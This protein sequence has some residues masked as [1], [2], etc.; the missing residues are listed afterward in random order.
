MAD[1]APRVDDAPVAAPTDLVLLPDNPAPDGIEIVWFENRNRRRV[2][3]AFAPD[4]KG[5][6]KTR[7]TVIVA[8]GRTEFIEKYFEVAR[9]LQ[10]RGFAVVIFDWP[11]Q[12][13]SERMRRD[14]MQGHVKSF[15]VYVEAMVRGLTKLEKKLPKPWI[16]L[17]HSMGGTIMLEA[18]RQGRLKV[19]A[20][21]FSAP[22]WGL[23]IWF[24]L[25]WAVYAARAIGLGGLPA[26]QP[27]AEETFE[28]N[29]LTGDPVRWSL[30]RKL[31]GAQP[32]LAVGEPTIAWVDAS[33]KTIRGFFRPGALD[34]L[35]DTPV[36]VAAAEK[37]TVVSGGAQRRL[38]KRFPDAKLLKIDDARH[39]ILMETDERRAEFWKAFD[40]LCKRAGV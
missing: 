40:A 21:A 12:G 37:E 28:N 30:Y 34:G 5:P 15:D 7:G 10:A 6:P 14:A 22:M 19:R 13:L 31:V 1:E 3:M 32:E 36:L 11:G 33:L 16:A 39:E 23:R 9:D 17:S 18:L 35:R 38:E 24:G 27:P 20:A 8:P 26:R 25:R 4:P 2:R 29:E